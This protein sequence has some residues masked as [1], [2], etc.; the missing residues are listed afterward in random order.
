M[1]NLRKVGGWKINHALAEQFAN[2]PQNAPMPGANIELMGLIN[3]LESALTKASAI[4][5]SLDEI[6]NMMGPYASA[7]VDQLIQ[8][9]VL[10]FS[11][12]PGD[13]PF[14]E[15]LPPDPDQLGQVPSEEWDW[16]TFKPARN[17]SLKR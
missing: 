11:P 2:D 8:Y 9:G 7:L 17:L 16:K 13:N 14:N 5:L 10:H 4:N 1:L 3:T 6:S 12:D 15:G